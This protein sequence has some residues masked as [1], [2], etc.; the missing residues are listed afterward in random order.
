[1][2][3]LDRSIQSKGNSHLKEMTVGEVLSLQ[4]QEL[5][6]GPFTIVDGDYSV[7]NIAKCYVLH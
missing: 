6:L 2:D 1:M 3:R 5:P 4:T 7:D